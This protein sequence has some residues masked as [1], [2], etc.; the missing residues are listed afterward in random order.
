MYASARIVSHRS[1]GGLAPDSSIFSAYRAQKARTFSSWIDGVSG[2][3]Y[4]RA[5]CTGV[6]AGAAAGTHKHCDSLETT[7]NLSSL[8]HVDVYVNKTR[9]I[10][11]VTV[12]PEFPDE[13]EPLL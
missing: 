4:C 1:K 6:R 7:R 2:M 11:K 9:Q 5:L 10:C 12:G 3:A 13:L 8:V